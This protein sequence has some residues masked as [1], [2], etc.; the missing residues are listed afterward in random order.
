MLSIY[1]KMST[2]KS[3]YLLAKSSN[4]RMTQA[5]RWVFI[6]RNINNY[7]VKLTK[8]QIYRFNIYEQNMKEKNKLLTKK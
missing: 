1:Y 5:F 8:L 4:L 6:N 2:I 3:K 7:Y